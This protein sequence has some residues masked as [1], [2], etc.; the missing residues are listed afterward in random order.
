MSPSVCEERAVGPGLEVWWL[1]GG[2][3]R[4]QDYCQ[5]EPP[6]KVERTRTSQGRRTSTATDLE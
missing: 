1:S 2:P 3:V 5:V 4:G 6:S